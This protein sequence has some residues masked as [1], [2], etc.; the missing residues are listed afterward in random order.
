MDKGRIGAKTR[1][2]EFAIDYIVIVVYLVLLFAAT[3]TFYMITFGEIPVVSQWQSQLIA[4]CA[5]IIPIVIIF[6]IL[7]Y[8]APFGTFGKR[9]AGLRVSY[10]TRAYWRSL[11]RNVV[12]FLPWQLGNF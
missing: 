6:S 1:L 9:K 3:R 12:K 7:D 2:K 8:R 4:T 10:K 5:S 11:V